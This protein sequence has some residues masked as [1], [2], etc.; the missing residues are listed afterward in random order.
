MQYAKED[1]DAIKSGRWICLKS[2]YIDSYPSHISLLTVYCYFILHC[3]G[4]ILDFS[5]LCGNLVITCKVR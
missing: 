5:N 3:R 4:N 1:L 2:I